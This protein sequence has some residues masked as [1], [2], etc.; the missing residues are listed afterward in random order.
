MKKLSLIVAGYIF[1]VS[2][3]A[4]LSGIKNIPGDY[5]DLTTAITDLNAQG[6][7]MGE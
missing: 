2:A 6:V 3:N 4:Q 5:P 1:C 7:G